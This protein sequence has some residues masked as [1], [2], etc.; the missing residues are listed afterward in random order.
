VEY[1]W[2]FGAFEVIENDYSTNSQIDNTFDPNWVRFYHCENSSPCY[3][4]CGGHNRASQQAI[5]P[6]LIELYQDV[7][8]TIRFSLIVI[9]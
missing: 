9:G 1:V 6:E 8:Y 3:I 4:L 7:A 5:L 2:G